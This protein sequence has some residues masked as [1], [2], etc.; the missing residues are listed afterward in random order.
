MNKTPT[1]EIEVGLAEEAKEYLR[2]TLA[3]FLSPFR[4]ATAMYL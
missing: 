1:R 4:P 3:V 2:T